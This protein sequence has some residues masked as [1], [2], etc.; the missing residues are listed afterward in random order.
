MATYIV[1]EN[2]L[3]NDIALEWYGD[4]DRG[5]VDLINRNPQLTSPTQNVFVGEVL[6][7]GPPFNAEVAEQLQ[8][9]GVATRRST[10]IYRGIGYD[11]ISE[12]ATEEEDLIDQDA[13]L[14]PRNAIIVG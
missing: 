5:M 14:C 7:V 8:L 12:C 6:D 3:L 13:R 2:Q 11:L 10:D 4:H 1:K 9:Q